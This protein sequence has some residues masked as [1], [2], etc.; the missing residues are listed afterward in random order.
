VAVRR[1]PGADRNLLVYSHGG[2][3]PAA[4]AAFLILHP[5]VLRP[6]HGVGVGLPSSSVV[7]AAGRAWPHSGLSTRSTRR[8]TQLPAKGPIT[9]F[10]PH[11]TLHALRNCLS[12]KGGL[13]GE[14]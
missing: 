5:V 2:S 7:A 14:C 4:P 3:S 11:N 1:P 13:Q 9:V 12:P 6:P 8:Y 10:I